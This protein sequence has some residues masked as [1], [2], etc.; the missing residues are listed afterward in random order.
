MAS[1]LLSVPTELLLN[2]AEAVDDAESLRSFALTCKFA[3]LV[4][5]PVLYRAVLVT[6]S[7]QASCL[8]QA[9]Q[10]QQPPARPELVHVLDLRPS[11]DQD[12]DL[13]ALTPLIGAM[14]ELRALSME[15]PFANYGHWLSSEA[16]DR[17]EPLM[18]GF[19]ALFLDAQC[20]IGLQNLTSLTIH[21]AG[22][23]S[24]FWWLTEFKPILTLPAL[25]SLTVSNAVLDDDL[26]DGLATF[27]GTTPLT[28]LELIECFVSHKALDAVL[29][30]PRAL[31][32]CHM[33]IMRYNTPPSTNCHQASPEQQLEALHQQHHSL[34]RLTWVDEHFALD[35]DVHRVSIV[36][37][38]GLSDFTELRTL[39]LDGAS[40]LLLSTLLS[41][42]APPNLDRLRII[43]HDHGTLLDYLTDSVTYPRILGVPPPFALHQHLPRLHYLDL[44]FSPLAHHI[45]ELLWAKPDRRDHVQRLGE[46]CHARGICLIIFAAIRDHTYPPY[47]FGEDP[48]CE[49]L[50]YRADN[51]WFSPEMTQLEHLDG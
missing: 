19:R 38:G 6:T 12:A 50:A 37:G 7:S 10:Q 15:S 18:Q 35:T 43:R 5:E 36:P 2:I 17:W 9:L 39:T 21:W 34:Q 32:S 28:H 14:T 4:A 45:T 1:P 49:E 24:P 25:Q 40:A 44:V 11:Y 27:A 20:G 8:A 30:L 16:H 48:P 26:I 33:G 31:R 41:E 47:L 51:A 42:C 22:A 3:R 23:G 29:A 46:D 13:E